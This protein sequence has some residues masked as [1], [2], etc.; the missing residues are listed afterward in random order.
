MKP[1]QLTPKE[2]DL[3]LT[4]ICPDCGAE[5]LLPGPSGGMSQNMLCGKCKV[6]FCVSPVLSERIHQ[7]CT[8]ERMAEVYGVTPNR[9]PVASFRPVEAHTRIDLDSALANGCQ[10][11]GCDHKNH[12][13][14]EML[15]LNGRCHPDA[16]TQAVYRASGI[17]T[18]HC[19]ECRRIIINISV[20]EK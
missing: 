3:L 20:S 17:L 11:P 7:P 4:G 12:G 16:G 14:L 18:L 10:N 13:P 1:E 5:L 6:E 8:P 19:K 15:F 2:N 9:Q